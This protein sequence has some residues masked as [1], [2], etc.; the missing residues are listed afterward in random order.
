MT[1]ERH[2]IVNRETWLEMRSHDLTASDVAAVSHC[3]PYRTALSVFVD[4]MGMGM[5][6]ESSIMRRGRWL[7]SAAADA[8]I[9]LHPHWK[10]INPQVYLRDPEIR[11]GATPD[12]LAEE[13]DVEGLINVQIKCVSKPTFEKWNGEVPINY[14]LQTLTE[15]M[16]L[17][18]R[19]S[20]VAAFVIST[21]DADLVMFE[22]P[23]HRGA[24]IR[25][26]QTADNFWHDMKAGQF[27]KPDYTRDADTIAALYSVPT[28]KKVADLSASNRIREILERRAVLKEAIKAETEEVA[29]I[30]TEI[31]DNIGDSEFASLPGWKLSWKL[32]T[33][34]AYTVPENTT[35]VLRVTAESEEDA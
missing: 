28:P 26:R 23:R 4:K 15:G 21:Y 5:I 13:E 8:I 20:Y 31:K 7:E 19:T 3:D 18:A 24:E 10:V 16:L 2:P 14:L 12:R 27:P 32:Q 11:L 35:R 25:I 34:K 22:V 9:E 33:R 29:A 17:D 6:N 30:D 1:V